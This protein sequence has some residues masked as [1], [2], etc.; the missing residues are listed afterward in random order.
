MSLKLGRTSLRRNNHR[1]IDTVALQRTSNRVLPNSVSFILRISE[2]AAWWGLEPSNQLRGRSLARDDTED[3][4][5]SSA[6]GR[7]PEYTTTGK[8][9]S[10]WRDDEIQERVK[11][12]VDERLGGCR[13]F[14]SHR[15]HHH[16]DSLGKSDDGDM[17]GAIAFRSRSIPNLNTLTTIDVAP[18]TPV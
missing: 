17:L 15:P 6:L 11:I 16:C 8:Q 3:A 10:S 18:R 12:P 4:S 13:G 1:S 2:P 7:A 5:A 9:T 14:K